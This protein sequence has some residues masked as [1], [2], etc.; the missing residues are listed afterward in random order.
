MWDALSAVGTL[1]AVVVALGLALLSEFQR[2]KG[3]KKRA[4]L[5]ASR[6]L[7][8]VMLLADEVRHRMAAFAFY[9]DGRD[10]NNDGFADE[11]LTL[12]RLV[13]AISLESIY[14]LEPL[15]GNCASR[16]AM[17]LGIIDALGREVEYAKALQ[18]WKQMSPE[19]R[20]HYTA[21]WMSLCSSA[22]DYLHMVR[23]ELESAAGVAAP[24]PSAED[25]YGPWHDGT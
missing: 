6:L 3:N 8:S 10:G 1:L 25:I 16:L 9:E 21:R 4:G 12:R 22:A 11:V 19:W 23:S 17:A 24:R 18:P 20:K 5:V 15:P 7:E 13:E 14:A 2:R